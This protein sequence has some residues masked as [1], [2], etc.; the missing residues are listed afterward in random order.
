[1]LDDIYGYPYIARVTLAP[2]TFF[3][4]LSDRTR[5]RLLALLI[6]GELCVCDLTDALA[7]SQP[8]VSRHLA[9]LREAGIV[10][11]RRRG[12]W[13]HYRLQDDLPSWAKTVLMETFSRVIRDAPFRSDRKL[14]RENVRRSKA[15]CA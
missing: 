15:R 13:I 14:L 1:M 12:V 3:R 10:S 6:N 2:E 11:D 4:I 5:L 7:L 9:A 8:M